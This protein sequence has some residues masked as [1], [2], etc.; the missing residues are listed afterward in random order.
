MGV[1][2]RDAVFHDFYLVLFVQ[3]VVVQ[4]GPTASSNT[5]GTDFNKHVPIKI[6]KFNRHV[7]IKVLKFNRHVPI[8]IYFFH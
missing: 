4:A 6:P 7:P 2:P 1:F 5:S 8:K 3:R